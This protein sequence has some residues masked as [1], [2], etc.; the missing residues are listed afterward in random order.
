MVNKILIAEDEANIRRIVANSLIKAG[1]KVV[2]ACNGEEAL[3]KVQ[4][5]NE[6][7][8]AILDVM[9]PK[10]NGF[11]VC[12]K[13][14]S[15]SFMPIIILTALDSDQDQLTGFDGGADDYISKPF[16][17]DVLVARVKSLLRRT[18]LGNLENM[19][20]EGLEIRYH[21]RTVFVD[22]NRVLMTP[23]EF[24]LL[25]YLI[26]NKNL[27]LTRDQILATVW[28]MDYLGDDRTVDTHI[29]CIRA[30]LGKYGE[31]IVTIRKVG[32]KFEC[33]K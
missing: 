31:Y 4:E 16:S 33:L 9:M 30:K 25:Y 15:M 32:Y 5:D 18:S 27:V 24:D 20:L 13:I 28:N 26:K 1:F 23:K 22:N 14:R 3:E 29:K 8:M 7:I 21:E 19:K 2:E 17:V 12:A 11:E 6:I 10:I